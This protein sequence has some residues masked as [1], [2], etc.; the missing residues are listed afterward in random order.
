[1]QSPSFTR[2]ICFSELYNS[3]LDRQCESGTHHCCQ[4][5]G[6]LPPLSCSFRHCHVTSL[7]GQERYRCFK[8]SGTPLNAS[9][10]Q[11][12]NLSLAEFSH[13]VQ[14]LSI[15]T[16][17]NPN[18]DFFSTT[19]EVAALSRSIPRIFPESPSSRVPVE[20]FDQNCV[21]PGDT[22]RNEARRHHPHT[23]ECLRSYQIGLYAAVL[24]GRC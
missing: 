11:L 18:R 21:D 10:S 9:R 2:R 20:N 12:F 6:S 8:D 7:S 3:H 19:G 22:R 5:E 15:P 16:K 14:K 4:L 1:M 24:L 13:L 23:F 17:S